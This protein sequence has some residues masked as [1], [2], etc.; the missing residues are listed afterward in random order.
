MDF[1]KTA[2]LLAILI[3]MANTMLFFVVQLPATQDGSKNIDNFMTTQGQNN[4]NSGITQ[5]ATDQ[6]AA[7]NTL[8]NSAAT[9]FST[10]QKNIFELGADALFSA[11]GYGAFFLKYISTLIT[12]VATWVDLFLPPATWWGFALG[13]IIKIPVYFVQA[14]GML[15]LIGKLFSLGSVS[16]I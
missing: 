2:I 5:L 12:G 15:A 3:M 10:D 11:L 9:E 7:L 1:E 16:R 4:V 6:N 14:A 8:S 13:W